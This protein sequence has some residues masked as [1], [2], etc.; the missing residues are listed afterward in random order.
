MKRR[1]FFRA[2]A[3]VRI[4]YGHFVRTLALAEMMSDS[5]EC[6]LFTA[7]PSV[8]QL[9]DLEKVCP[10]VILSEETKYNDF[11]SHL[12]GDEIVVLDNYFFTSEYQLR[13]KE[14]GCKLICFG[15]ND[16]HYYSDVL[17]N[18]AESNPR[19]FD[20]EP[21][22]RFMLGIDWV[23]LRREFRNLHPLP[24][25]PSHRIAICYGGTDQFCLT[26]KT[27]KVIQNLPQSY[28][29]DVI[30]SDRFGANRFESL[31]QRGVSCHINASAAEMVGMFEH[32]DYLISSASTITH[33][34]IACGLPVLCGYYVDN[35]Q[36]MYDYFVS[37]HLVIG[38]GNM[39]SNG[40]PALLADN[41]IHIDER[42]TTI[43]S[44]V[45]GDIKNRYKNLFESL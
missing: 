18:Y 45:Y 23:I 11:L 42:Q 24:K 17:I 10:Y 9:A 29:I 12:S 35:Q 32:C 25:T 20:A 13:I 21:Y 26:E 15:T 5:F 39:L 36:R 22:T 7:N 30:A 43:R 40:F 14:K 41:L 31:Q 2:D 1:I 44:F 8:S 16:R 19:I 3:S 37:E 27:V 6:T 28:S 4:G 34:G 38:L 33:E